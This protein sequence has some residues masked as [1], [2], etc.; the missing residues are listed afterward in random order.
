MP[1]NQRPCR[2]F[3]GGGPR[4][5]P[6]TPRC[7]RRPGCARARGSDARLVWYRVLS[8]ASRTMCRYPAR[9]GPLAR[10]SDARTGRLE[11][12]CSDASA[13]GLQGTEG[14][15]DVTLKGQGELPCT[16]ALTRV[17]QTDGAAARL[18]QSCQKV[19]PWRTR[20]D[21]WAPHAS[22]GGIRSFPSR[23][24]RRAGPRRP[25]PGGG[26]TLSP[27]PGRARADRGD[28]G[29]RALAEEQGAQDGE[30][31]EQ[32]AAPQTPVRRALGLGRTPP[33]RTRPR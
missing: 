17:S 19:S 22:V 7:P 13:T 24:V 2:P 33:R 15:P 8:A 20:G 11:E 14:W 28:G 12:L 25:A 23:V 32:G 29:R 16:R 30:A 10:Q 9:N 27:D 4:G 21:E 26:R 1:S 6:R 31:S 3:P 18:D 5:L